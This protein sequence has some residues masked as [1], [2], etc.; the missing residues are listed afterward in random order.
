MTDPLLCGVDAGT[1]RIRAI[2]FDLTGRPVAEASR[3]T[4]TVVVGP[5]Q[6]EHD[7]EALW[8]ATVEAIGEAVGSLDQPARVRGLAIAS[9]AEAGVLLDDAGA[10]LGPALAWYD[11]RPAPRLERLV[12]ELG[13]DRLHGITGL[14][15]DPTFTVAKL[16][17]LREQA[18]EVLAR[19]AAWLGIS[20]WLAYR[21]TGVRA[22]DHSI[23]SRTMALDLAAAAWSTELLDLVGLPPRLFGELARAG[24]RL[25]TVLP[26]LAATTGLPA[27]CAVGVA[28]HDHICGLLAVGAD[29]EG[30]LLDSMGT[31]EAL[32][33]VLDRPSRDPA[34]GRSGFNQG[35]IDAGRPRYYVFGGLPTSSGA[36]EWFR[37]KLAAGAPYATLL[38]EAAAVADDAHELMFLPQLRIGSPP[39]LDAPG[40]GAFLGI[41]D[42]CDRGALFRALLEGLAL[43]AANQVLV[44]QRLGLPRPHRITAIGGGSRNPLLMRL[45]ACLFGREVETL[46]MPEATALGAA[47][48]GGLAAGLFPD[49]AAARAGLRAERRLVAPDPA[50]PEPGRRAR[51]EA[52]A[53][54]YAALRPVHKRLR[55]AR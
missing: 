45:K 34:L 36:I 27:D 16:L 42:G 30:V 23:A 48:L 41:S 44:L 8:S 7:P 24:Q 3:P 9:M 47:L 21:L 39:Y 22:C 43:D 14:C 5:G 33:L 37:D 35:L 12:V 29:E 55:D 25:G 53:A 4:P 19:A 17:W 10:P 18:P 26:D 31:A 46:A 6:A 2:V 15:P 28:G 1:S 49:L 54:A 38:A 32:T 51:L 11:S 40:R 50:W 52:Y 13:A 20:G